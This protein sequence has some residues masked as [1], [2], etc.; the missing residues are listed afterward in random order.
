MDRPADAGSQQL[1]QRTRPAFAIETRERRLADRENL[2]A[3][4]QLVGVLDLHMAD[5]AQSRHEDEDIVVLRGPLVLQ[6]ERD[7]REKDPRRSSVRPI[8]NQIG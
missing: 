6:R 3:A 4:P 1:G 8:S 5:I 7:D 2:I